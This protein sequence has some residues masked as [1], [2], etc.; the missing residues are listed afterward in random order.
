MK[1]SDMRPNPSVP[2]EPFQ[3]A[4]LAA[5]AWGVL[6]G[7]LRSPV[8]WTYTCHLQCWHLLVS[9]GHRG[10]PLHRA[11][12]HVGDLAMSGEDPGTAE[13]MMGTTG[14]EII[15]DTTGLQGRG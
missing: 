2:I 15:P 6:W 12:W 10:R 13:L 14:P 1:S 11:V 9:V 3:A 5:G 8:C 7:A 4:V